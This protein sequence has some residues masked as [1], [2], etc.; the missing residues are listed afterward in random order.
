MRF[1]KY[2]PTINHASHDSLRI[3]AYLVGLNADKL[4]QTLDHK[5]SNQGGGG[6]IR[7]II[8][9][10]PYDGPWPPPSTTD[11]HTMLLPTSLAGEI[12]LHRLASD[13]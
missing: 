13:Q 5:L 4:L 9:M 6:E 2:P 3:A 10:L 8:L 12:W 11:L 1:E 7:T